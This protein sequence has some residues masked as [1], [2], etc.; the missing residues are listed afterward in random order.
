MQG[1]EAM[2]EGGLTTGWA[3]VSEAGSDISDKD[4]LVEVE[5]RKPLGS[6]ESSS[7]VRPGARLHRQRKKAKKEAEGTQKSGTDETPK[8]GGQVGTCISSC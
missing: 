7:W 6:E 3:D 2:E 8:K 1:E 4:R 5:G